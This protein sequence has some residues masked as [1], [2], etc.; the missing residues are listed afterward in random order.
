MGAT[1]SRSE[2]QLRRQIENFE[3]LLHLSK[4]PIMWE[5]D[6]S[7]TA[8]SALNTLRNAQYHIQSGRRGRGLQAAVTSKLLCTDRLATTTMVS[9]DALAVDINS[10]ESV[11]LKVSCPLRRVR[12]GQCAL[13]TATKEEPAYDEIHCSAI[14]RLPSSSSSSVC[15]LDDTWPRGAY[16]APAVD[17]CGAPAAQTCHFEQVSGEAFDI[18]EILT[19]G[20][21]CQ[22]SDRPARSKAEYYCLDSSMQTRGIQHGTAD[23]HSSEKPAGPGAAGSAR[24][25]TLPKRAFISFTRT[26][27]GLSE[28]Q[29]PIAP[30]KRLEI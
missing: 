23:E 16:S 12:T 2:K 26:D 7:V 10:C 11:P 28:C 15:S 5:D 17:A 13:V 8:H 9:F 24:D 21:R 6:S 30:D 19:S 1:A 29:T 22:T 27:S 20:G 4:R 25:D 3:A 18:C 14:R